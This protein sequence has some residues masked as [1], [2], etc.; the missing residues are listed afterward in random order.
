MI[1]KIAWRLQANAEGDLSERARRR[2]A[3]LAD[4]AE[5]RV[6]APRATVAPP[7]TTVRLAPRLA[8]RGR[9]EDP[10]VPPPRACI[11]NFHGRPKPCDFT[12]GW[13]ADSYAPSRG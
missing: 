9:H 6:M 7:R 10:R 8:N 5:V 1:R 11:V 12:T 3:E 2:A 13:V 4:D